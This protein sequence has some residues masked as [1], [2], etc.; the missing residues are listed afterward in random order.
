M[1]S[2]NNI[3]IT[4]LFILIFSTKCF[5]VN[6]EEATKDYY[7]L[8]EQ[9]SQASNTNGKHAKT[10]SSVVIDTVAI[11]QNR[12]LVLLATDFAGPITIDKIRLINH[13]KW[14]YGTLEI[15]HLL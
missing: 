3:F 1:K 7:S 15:Q 10:I 12:G 14:L 8:K 9:L 5:A 13:L 2:L 6:M 11:D 4:L